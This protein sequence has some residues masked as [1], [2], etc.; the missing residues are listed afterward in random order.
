MRSV[1]AAD[2]SAGRDNRVAR[3]SLARRKRAE[4]ALVISKAAPQPSLDQPARVRQPLF[5]GGVLH[6]APLLLLVLALLLTP[7]TC[8]A[9]SGPHSLFVGR[10]S[11]GGRVQQAHHHHAAVVES[12][13]DEVAAPGPNLREFSGTS[14]LAAGL[15]AVLIARAQDHPEDERSLRHVETSSGLQAQSPLLDPPPPR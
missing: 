6:V 8:R 2:P 14:Q 10:P 12:E 11:A 5:N 15:S 13:A 7:I 3:S 4:Q 1:S 9:M